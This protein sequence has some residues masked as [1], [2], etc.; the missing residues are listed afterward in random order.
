MSLPTTLRYRVEDIG[1]MYSIILGS[2]ASGQISDAYREQA[3]ALCA[4]AFDS[5]TVI[6]S[7]G[8]FKGAREKSLIFQFAT[9]EPDKV[10]RLAAQLAE[11]FNQEGVGIMRPAGPGASYTGY[12]RV[13][14]NRPITT[15]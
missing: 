11:V 3:I 15:I 10:I 12:S 1:P 9:Q 8:F 6:K 7:E 5:F 14:P 13:I 2:A 4:A